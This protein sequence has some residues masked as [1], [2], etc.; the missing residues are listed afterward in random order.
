MS[1]QKFIWRNSDWLEID[2]NAP[3]PKPKG[4]MIC[5]FKEFVS[6]IDGSVIASN[7]D[8][9]AHERQY[10]VI[11]VGNEKPSYKPRSLPPVEATIK[12]AIEKVEAGY[13]ASPERGDVLPENTLAKEIING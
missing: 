2:L 5:T 12:E 4:P 7:R 9:R 8:L 13:V 6:P 1:R 11:Q 10:N 3:R